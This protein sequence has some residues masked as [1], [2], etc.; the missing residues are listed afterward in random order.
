M[1]CSQKLKLDFNVLSEC[2]NSLEGIAFEYLMAGQTNALE[3]PHTGVP[4]ITING[5]HTNEIQNEGQT[6][7]LKLVC[8]SYPVS[9]M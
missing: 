5:K 8:D 6:N 7:L 9:F 4:W 2:A 3:P 1:K